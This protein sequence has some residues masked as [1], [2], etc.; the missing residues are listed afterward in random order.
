MK[1][2]IFLL[3]LTVLP[4]CYAASNVSLFIAPYKD[5]IEI[6]VTARSIISKDIIASLKSG[7]KIKIEYTVFEKKVFKKKVFYKKKVTFKYDIINNIY[8]LKEKKTIRYYKDF[9]K[10]EKDVSTFIAKIKKKD[11]DERKLYG[12]I[13]IK[14][15]SITGVFAIIYKVFFD[16]DYIIEFP[17]KRII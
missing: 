14:G 6:T 4:L 7:E 3:V 8:I 11:Y 9:K 1:R 10:L 17:I 5:N 16:L 15:M 13:H 12:N 2:I